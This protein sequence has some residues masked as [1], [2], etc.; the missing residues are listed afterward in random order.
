[1]EEEEEEENSAGAV[2]SGSATA[3][4]PPAATPRTDAPGVG[5]VPPEILGRLS[6][7]SQHALSIAN[8]F[9][10]SRNR[11]DIHMEHLLVGLYQVR[12][13]PTQS[14]FERAGVS[15]QQLVQRLD[16][17]GFDAPSIPE[18]EPVS[19]ARSAPDFSRHAADVLSS[20]ADFASRAGSETIRSRHLLAAFFT[21]DC[22][23]GHRF[24][25]VAARAREVVDELAE[26]E[27]RNRRP[28]GSGTVAANDRV[29]REDQLGFTHYVKAFADLIEATE[30]QP[31]LTIGIFGSWGMGKSFLLNH[32]ARELRNRQR[33][34]KSLFARRATTSGVGKNERLN[35]HI[36]R[37]NAWE[38]NATER[39]WPGLVRKVMEEV[40][41]KISWWNWP[42]LWVRRASRKIRRN[43]AAT[44]RDRWKHL[45]VLGGVV[46]LAGLLVL[47]HFDSIRLF[48]KLQGDSEFRLAAAILGAATALFT[49]FINTLLTPLGNWVAAVTTPREKYGT[50]LDYMRDIRDDLRLL[51]LRL[52]NGVPGEDDDE[53][54]VEGEARREKTRSRAKQ[55]GETPGRVLIV[56]DD[57]DRCEPD[58]AVE[59]LQ[60]IN[61]LLN[62]DSFI[63][64]MGIDARVITGAVERHYKDL[65]G[66]AGI[67]GYEY[68]DKI[69]QIPF[70]IPEPNER[71]LGR[72]LE[73]QLGQTVEVVVARES[74]QI[75]E[76]GEQSDRTR[77]EQA[78]SN[79]RPDEVGADRESTGEQR[80]PSETVQS[81]RFTRPEADAFGAM[82]RFLKPNPRHIKRLVNV[83]VLVRSLRVQQSSP[84]P[85]HA[86][87]LVRWL[88]LCAQ[89][90]YTCH[91][92]LRRFDEV[93]RNRTRSAE[94][95]RSFEKMRHNPLPLLYQEVRLRLNPARL[96]KLDYDPDL[97]ERLLS[98]D[99]GWATWEEL[100]A[101]RQYT[102]N[103]NPAVQ[104]ELAPGEPAV[105]AGSAANAVSAPARK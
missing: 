103:F 39:I 31:P 27:E 12:G 9:R 71:D 46:A 64:C 11:P 84:Q 40:D 92:L 59:V 88:V 36:V 101:L 48:T 38:Y 100:K 83:Y 90:P 98:L 5:S 94:A 42:S 104:S 34:R 63:V 49:L 72:F 26:A 55:R 29:A 105:E 7:S 16:E 21:V 41:R 68:L 85:L 86:T 15:L 6:P 47:R 58:K 91:E 17:H 57:L 81:P 76:S 70:S 30:T 95:H 44:A 82:T 4:R 79:A 102:I 60:A 8:G 25:D 93:E 14:A 77:Q 62:F 54:T 24:N 10:L 80:K 97:L 66:P 19:I 50:P 51:D 22:V 87:S 78:A 37:F 18:L 13:G 3:A 33:P 74:T 1:M 20:G 45:V 43:L 35:V 69:I 75:V 32:I 53:A 23:V 28:I 56:I 73:K 89:W 67:S 2:R 52:R 65:L 61:L 96:Q 99:G